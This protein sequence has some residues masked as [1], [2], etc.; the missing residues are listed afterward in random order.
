MPN[1]GILTVKTRK[2]QLA[3][4]VTCRQRAQRIEIKGDCLEISFSDSGCGIEKDDLNR[5][6]DTFF[7]T[8]KEG[9]GTGLGLSISYKII[10]NLKGT[11]GVD[12]EVGKG[13]TFVI[14]LPVA[15]S[16][17]NNKNDIK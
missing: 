4:C 10:E 2:V 11:I 12:S 3:E 7:T 6:F 13:T 17:F 9:R 16:S 14:N 5:I 8:K 1:G 15:F